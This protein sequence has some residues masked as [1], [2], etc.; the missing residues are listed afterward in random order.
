VRDVHILGLRIIQPGVVGVSL[1]TSRHG[2]TLVFSSGQELDSVLY[3]EA[4]MR[5]YESFNGFF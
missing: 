4:G 1:N 2:R 3:C 5:S